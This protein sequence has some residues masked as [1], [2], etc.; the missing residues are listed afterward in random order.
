MARGEGF[1]VV[2]GMSGLQ[3]PLA[4]IFR[5]SSQIRPETAAHR[6]NP[7]LYAS[8]CEAR[9]WGS[10]GALRFREEV[11]RRCGKGCEFYWWRKNRIKELIGN[12]RRL[13][14]GADGA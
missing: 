14:D 4:L 6:A 3:V 11:N 2:D 9:E 8:G 7:T 5:I 10:P 1:I 13:G 12:R